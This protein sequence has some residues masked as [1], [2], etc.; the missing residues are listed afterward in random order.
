[1]YVH[2]HCYQ[3]IFR[4]HCTLPPKHGTH[5]IHVRLPEILTPPLTI[6]YMYPR[7]CRFIQLDGPMYVRLTETRLTLLEDIL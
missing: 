1:M 4:I 6:A 5:L 3:H 2:A 7:L